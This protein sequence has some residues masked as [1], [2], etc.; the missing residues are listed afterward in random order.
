MD[1]TFSEIGKVFRTVGKLVKE[2]TE[3]YFGNVTPLEKALREVADEDTCTIPN[4]L[5]RELGKSTNDLQ[6][7]HPIMQCIWQ[8]LAQEGAA[9]R[10]TYKA[11]SLLEYVMLFGP[12][13]ALEDCKHAAIR[14]RYLCGFR[15]HDGTRE[16]GGGVRQ[17]AHY[18]LEL[19]DQPEALAAARQRAVEDSEKYVGIE[20]RPVFDIQGFGPSGFGTTGPS[21]T[22]PSQASGV[23]PFVHS[24]SEQSQRPAW[25]PFF[26]GPK[27]GSPA[28][29]NPFATINTFQSETDARRAWNVP[30]QAAGYSPPQMGFSQAPQTGYDVPPMR[31]SSQSNVPVPMAPPASGVMTTVKSNGSYD[32]FVT[33]GGSLWDDESP[34]Q[35]K[36]QPPEDFFSRGGEDIFGSADPAPAA[37]PVATDLLSFDDDDDDG[38]NS[39]EPPKE[40]KDNPLLL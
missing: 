2:K 34:A 27:A 37:K 19:L 36:D 6:S 8:G 35:P 28:T 24:L 32:P 30:P 13:R 25:S 7:Y 1:E 3:D 12:P 4:S 23:P 10:R 33:G 21:F 20:N 29:D 14:I 39:M 38:V 11:L 16:Q 31:S 5:L 22:S 26:S 40:S 17:K 15:Y 18:I 9:W